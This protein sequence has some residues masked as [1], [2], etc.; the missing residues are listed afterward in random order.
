VKLADAVVADRFARVRARMAELE[1]EALLLS[2]GADLPWLTGYEAMP[3]ERLTMLVLPVAGDAVLVVP[4]LEAPRVVERS[5]FAV[6]PWDETDDPVE[7]VA[8]LLG[9]A[10]NGVVRAAIG[11]H[12]WA[13]FVVE[14]LAARPDL[15]LR[16]GVEVTGPLRMV[17]DA[18]EI[19]ALRRAAA[20]VDAIAV[21]LRDVRFSGRTEA[22]LSREIVE[23]MLAAG[24]ERANFAIVATGPNGA[25]PHHEPTDRVIEPGDVV[26]CDFGGTMDGYCS[27]ITRMFVVG[28]PGA[29][30]Q[31]VYD[32]LAAAQEAGVQSGKPG[33]ACEAVDAATRAVI[34]AAGYGEFFVHRTG[35]G[36]GTEEHEDPYMVAG[37]ELPLAPGHAYSV[38]PGIYLPGRFGMR[39]E[40]IVV[41]TPGGPERLTRAP[42]DLAVVS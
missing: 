18:A 28:E 20:A 19:E 35:H 9:P 31:A 39:L 36:I 5:S 21:G 26:L 27:D 41:C 25:S 13:R 37:N 14:L 6:H 10:P 23:R 11:D 1:V 8:D 15:A 42:R 22:E 3:L 33:L 30:V 4:R 32:V 38:E 2:T 16:R 34:T 12:T 29:E 24:H 7:V 40:D 17:K